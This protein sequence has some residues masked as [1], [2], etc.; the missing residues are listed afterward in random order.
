[1]KSSGVNDG[2]HESA[3]PVVPCA[4]VMTGHPPFGGVPFGIARS[5]VTAIVWPASEVDEYMTLDIEPFSPAS[6]TGYDLSMVPGEVSLS[7]AGTA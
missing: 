3:R 6:C 2:A 5:P 4:H 7:D 1:M